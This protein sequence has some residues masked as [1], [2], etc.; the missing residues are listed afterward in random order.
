MGRPL[1]ALAGVHSAISS[2]GRMQVSMSVLAV[3]PVTPRAISQAYLTRHFKRTIG[4]TPGRYLAD[5]TESAPRPM[6]R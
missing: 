4:L 5:L 2:S 1:G 6:V 3:T